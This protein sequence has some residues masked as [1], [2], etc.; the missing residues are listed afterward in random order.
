VIN[1]LALNLQTV[2]NYQRDEINALKARVRLLETLEIKV[3]TTA[4][5]DGAVTTPKL[6]DS[7][8]TSAKLADS[9]VTSAKLADSAVTSAKIINSAVTNAKL[10]DMVQA[11]IKGRQLTGGTGAPEDLTASQVNS[12]VGSADLFVPTATITAGVG[13]DEGRGQLGIPPLKV[14]GQTTLFYR[15]TT[16]SQGASLEF[17]KRRG[18]SS[19]V[20]S[21]GDHLGSIGWTGADSS[22]F[23]AMG[24]RILAIVDGTP[25][26]G[27]MPT[28]LV[29]QISPAGSA[30]PTEALRITNAG[31]MIFT[32]GRRIETDEVRAR[33]ADGLRL[34]NLSGN[35]GILV[36]DNALV[37]IG[38][39]PD[40]PSA[41]NAAAIISN[42]G[43]T[44]LAVRNSTDDIEGVVRAGTSFVS[45]GA[46]TNHELRF[47]HNNTERARFDTAGN[48]IVASAQRIEVNEIRN[49]SNAGGPWHEQPMSTG[50]SARTIVSG[51]AVVAPRFEITS[52]SPLEINAGGILQLTA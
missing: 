34:N 31:N 28:R 30:S 17:L 38:P 16:D 27:D 26:S 24:A 49:T 36:Q 47:L 51:H 37:R 39:G 44:S 1:T 22:T 20:L 25:A 4:I 11:R 45:V 48:L 23:G 5:A 7:A 18:A 3:S 29:F 50:A 40:A 52:G 19:N 35:P 43:A 32:D 46:V 21:A 14:K 8:V 10:A 33:D 13:S 2:Q 6:A 12:I 42:N 9:A 15:D 41:A